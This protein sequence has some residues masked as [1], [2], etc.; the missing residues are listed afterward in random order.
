MRP[1]CETLLG[2]LSLRS[3]GHPPFA[4]REDHGTHSRGDQQRG[5]HLEGDQVGTEHQGREPFHISALGGIGR[6]ESCRGRFHQAVADS[7]DQQ[8][9]EADSEEKSS[10][11]LALDGLDERVRGVDSDHHE[12][13]EEQH[14]H[15][16]GVNDDLD[17]SQE[18]S[19][20]RNVEDR[21][22]DH[23]EGDEQR[24]VHGLSRD[25]HAERTDHREGATDPEDD[26]FPGSHRSA[27]HTAS[28]WSGEEPVT[29]LA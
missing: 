13:E 2:Q 16:T 4:V 20:I 1:R 28:P 26:R 5:G 17:H 25:H 21:Q 22:I 8:N 18:G 10:H 7:C 12:D 27:V 9:G 3:F 23:G 29:L 24:A 15:G 11:P 19:R 6:V 14:H